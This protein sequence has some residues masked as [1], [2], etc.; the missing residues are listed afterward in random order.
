MSERDVPTKHAYDNS[1]AEQ[2]ESDKRIYE[3]NELKCD[4]RFVSVIFLVWIG[5][6][7]ARERREKGKNAVHAFHMYKN[8]RFFFF[9]DELVSVFVGMQWCM[10]GTKSESFKT[11]H[12]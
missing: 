7:R 10:C 2:F 1:G 5:K 11:A 4:K 6:E 3:S 12:T 9:D 8:G